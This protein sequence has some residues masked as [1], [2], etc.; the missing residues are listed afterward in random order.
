MNKFHFVRDLHHLEAR[1]LPLRYSVSLEIEPV[2]NL[3][4]SYTLVIKHASPTNFTLKLYAL[5]S[6]PTAFTVM[7]DCTCVRIDIVWDNQTP[8]CII[9]RIAELVNHSTTTTTATTS[10]KNEQV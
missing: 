2:D 8:D 3:F 9:N 7:L 1:F 5:E 6:Q 4:R 10:V